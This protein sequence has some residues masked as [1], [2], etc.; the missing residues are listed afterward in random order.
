M[1][2]AMPKIPTIKLFTLINLMAFCI[3]SFVA[4][5]ATVSSV[6]LIA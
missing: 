5:F 1:V 6:A 4:A 3:S 2:M